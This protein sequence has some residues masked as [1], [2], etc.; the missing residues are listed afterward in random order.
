[1]R[2]LLVLIVAA[3][4]C[5][6]S[7]SAQANGNVPAVVAV[8]VPHAVLVG[9]GRMTYM[10]MDIYDARLYAPEGVFVPGHPM[11]LSLTYLRSLSGA[12][13]ADSTVEQMR[14]MGM[15]D[16]V[17]LAGWHDVLRGIF[18][19]VEDGTTLTGVLNA[20]GETL[21]YNG[22]TEI[23]HVSDPAFGR[24]FFGIWLS[25]QTEDPDL[26]NELLHITG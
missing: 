4:L 16:E 1:M 20:K 2:K 19:D 26:R 7:G 21:F 8:S 15:Q 10:M 3:V 9:T 12:R 5:F 17:T 18:P 24:Y 11:A 22:D 25:P 13:I 14:R 23:G 6:S